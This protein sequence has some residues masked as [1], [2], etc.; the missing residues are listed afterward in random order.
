MRTERETEKEPMIEEHDID[1]DPWDD[2]M[3]TLSQDQIMKQTM[4]S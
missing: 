2:I 3:K 4:N 1:H